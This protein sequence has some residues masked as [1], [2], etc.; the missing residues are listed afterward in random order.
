VI[1]ETFEGEA[2]S[3]R[4][5][6]RLRIG[7][8]LGSLLV[9]AP[10]L[11]NSQSAAVVQVRVGKH[12]GYTRVV[13][14]LDEAVDYTIR[15]TGESREIVVDLEAG[16]ARRV[17]TSRSDL[18]ETVSIQP[19]EGGAV[20]RIR[21]TEAPVHI[22]EMLLS[23]PP[24]IVL[25]LR[26]ERAATAAAEPSDPTGGSEEPVETALADPTPPAADPSQEPPLIDVGGPDVSAGVAPPGDP[27]TGES[28]ADEPPQ[29]ADGGEP[30]LDPWHEPDLL[31]D[32]A[33]GGELAG[34]DPGDAGADPAAGLE[35]PMPEPMDDPL[36]ASTE[37]PGA[38]PTPTSTLEPAGDEAPLLA[39]LRDPR[40]LLALG[41]GLVVAVLL[42]G[43]SRSR[44]R[45]KRSGLFSTAIPHLPEDEPIV[46]ASPE[47]F[48]DQTLPRIAQA[49]P[50][51]PDDRSL[52]DS[53][54]GIEEAGVEE[55]EKPEVTHVDAGGAM[56]PP[57]VALPTAG[58]GSVEELEQ[59]LLGLERRLE[60][61]LDA[62]DRLERHVAAQ[63]EELRVQRAAIARTQ[64]VL[65][66]LTRPDDAPTEPALKTPQ[67]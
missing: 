33:P 34:T 64:R 39:M 50:D 45:D 66:N 44:R 37:E 25:D 15:P 60:E 46:E 32:P 62:K 49:E 43:W 51:L 48:E 40:V 67:D 4:K 55:E 14:E 30:D 6:W 3:H 61:V 38:L 54:V 65:R 52:F 5:L 53:T 63:T 23:D 26:A 7:V 2:P 18:V 24:R 10:A 36:T 13:F 56:T 59:R 22:T 57:G 42:V 27:T 17:M 21:V 20:A 12:P 19:A 35:D 9:A 1:R 8:V 16:S 29:V 58:S 47:P 31:E 41:G 11:P 28:P